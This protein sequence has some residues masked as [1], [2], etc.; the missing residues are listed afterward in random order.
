MAVKKRI[1]TLLG[2]AALT[3]WGCLLVAGVIVYARYSD[4]R[5]LAALAVKEL[6]AVTGAA[7]SIAKVTPSLLPAPHLRVEGTA[8]QFGDSRFD[9]RAATVY[10]G[11]SSLLRLHFVPGRVELESPTF[12]RQS[13]L[14][15]HAPPNPKHPADGAKEAEGADGAGGAVSTHAR[16]KLPLPEILGDLRVEISNGHFLLNDGSHSLTGT[17]LNGTLRLPGL[18]DGFTR[19]RMD[20][21]T[22]TLPEHSGAADNLYLALHGVQLGDTSEPP[23]F[24]SA[25]CGLDIRSAAPEPGAPLHVELSLDG[26][27]TPPLAGVLRLNGSAPFAFLPPDT[28]LRLAL[29]FRLTPTGDVELHD[30]RLDFDADSAA[31]NATLAPGAWGAPLAAL[32]GRPPEQALT[33]PPKLSGTAVIDHLSLPRWFYFARRLPPGI[34]AALD[35]LRGELDFTLTPQR[36][37]VPRLTAWLC[38]MRFAGSGGVDDFTKPNIRIKAHT[39]AADVNAVLPE[40]LRKAPPAI[41]WPTPPPVDDNNDGSEGP[42]YDISLT[43]DSARAWRFAVSRF[44]FRCTPI[45]DGSRLQIDAGGFYGGALTSV[46]DIDNKVAVAVEVRQVDLEKPAALITGAPLITGQWTGKAALRGSDASFDHFLASLAGEVHG[47]VT[48][49]ALGRDAARRLAFTSLDYTWK[50]AG[51]GLHSPTLPPT[52]PFTGEWRLALRTPGWEGA[53]TLNGPL[54]F[55]STD[56][57]PLRMVDAPGRIEWAGHGLSASIEAR[58]G[59]DLDKGSLHIR[60]AAGK[61]SGGSLSGALA[62]TPE[63]NQTLWQGNIALQ[64]TALRGFLLRAGLAPAHMPEGT[65]QYVEYK[66]AFSKLGDTYSLTGLHGR[67]DD[68]TV[69]GSLRYSPDAAHAWEA[70]LALGTLNL[71]RYLPKTPPGQAGQT[72]DPWPTEW[73]DGLSAKG[74]VHVQ[75]LL[76][77]KLVQEKVRLPFVFEKNR[78]VSKGITFAPYT[79][80]GEADLELGISRAGYRGRL[81][82]QA[83]KA[84]A[85]LFSRQAGFATVLGGTTTVN[86]DVGGLLQRGADFPAALDG[87]WKIDVQGGYIADKRADGSLKDT[88]PFRQIS[89]SGVMQKGVLHTQDISL[90][91]RDMAASGRGVI[92][93]VQWTLDCRLNVSTT[94]LSNVPVVY[95]GSLDAPERSINPLNA[96]AGA[97][98]KLGSG[99][100]GLVGD[101][102]SSPFRLLRQ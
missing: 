27:G 32:L 23:R 19:L 2:I 100:F 95:S 37:D 76:I 102:L 13:G 92:D 4:P 8:V 60:Q 90:K 68:T 39:A 88:I 72:G 99:L 51:P 67:V 87:N 57:A 5:Q 81:R 73:A 82:Y 78:L 54:A 29:P 12:V 70:D 52:L 45:K 97:I 56:F 77:S 61:M 43:A 50:V 17:N 91:S 65:L 21:L 48:H 89:A 79:G 11:W 28:P 44:A 34:E 80:K 74:V 46:V 93:L 83:E 15:Q 66:S 30:A 64:S 1:S 9:V 18:L 58:C 31:I 22:W 7:W 10:M 26:E 47:Q 101:V 14:T 16:P 55:R 62:L 86:A 33:G 49:G 38:G 85:A 96:V 6:N 98:G 40:L 24:E 59:F 41:V 36:L 25:L 63:G 69:S 42:D 35:N 20:T 53:L 84:D 75:S 3:V 71:S 94:R